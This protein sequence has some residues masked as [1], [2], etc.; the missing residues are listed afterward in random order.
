MG[1]KAGGASSVSVSPPELVSYFLDNGLEVVLSSERSSP[2]VGVG[3]FYRAGFRLEPEGRTGFAHLFEHLMFQGTRH[4]PKPHFGNLI[5]SAGGLLNGSTRH[6][7]TNYYEVLPASAL[8]MAC[9]L[10]ADRMSSLDLNEETLRNQVDVVEEEVR[11]NVLN[12]PYGGFSWLW[13][14]QYAYST[15]P[16]CHNY[17][18]EF[19]D[20]EA[21]TVED[22][23][24]FYRTWYSPGNATLV[25]TGDFAVDEARKL[26]DR[27]LGQVEAREH[28]P[29]P[30]LDEPFPTARR[31]FHHQDPL[32]PTPQLA[33]GYPTAPFGHEDH[34]ALSLAARILTDGRSSR[35]QRSLVQGRE[36]LLHVGGGPHYP[37]GDSFEFLGPALFTFEATPRP[38]VTTANALDALDQ[39]LARF[40]DE[41][42]APEEVERAK[43]RELSSYHANNDSRLGRLQELGVMAAIH[44]RPQL[45]DEL[46]GRYELIGA[47]DVTRAVRNW[48]KL[49]RST[50][51]HWEPGDQPRARS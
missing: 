13:L 26:V 46:P 18:G 37:I 31:E 27:H 36:L 30:V 24:D 15:Y 16:N 14:S 47:E 11:G 4:V 8:E 48:L 42:P 40:A 10:E 12:Q 35:L 38:E 43:R 3:V 23:R 50:V 22:A 25:L 20:L 7:Y 39:E 44:R 6:D 9:F 51:L 41:G 17:Y 29:T 45:V 2:T 33:V 5:N 19:A 34:L 32:A 21:A 1:P 49:S 28:P